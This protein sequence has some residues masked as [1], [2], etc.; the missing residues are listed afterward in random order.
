MLWKQGNDEWKE[1][2]LNNV[3]RK[4]GKKE[5]L[6]EDPVTQIPPGEFLCKLQTKCEFEGKELLEYSNEESIIKENEVSYSHS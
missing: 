3:L 1:V 4:F 5:F 2:I 6:V